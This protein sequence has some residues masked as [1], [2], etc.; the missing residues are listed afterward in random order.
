MTTHT[1]SHGTRRRRS[2]LVAWYWL[3]LLVFL[4]QSAEAVDTPIPTVSPL[5]ST[6]PNGNKPNTI[7]NIL[8]HST[9]AGVIK[10]SATRLM[11]TPEKAKVI[12]E[13]LAAVVHYEELFFFIVLGWVALPALRMQY[14][15]LGMAGRGR[16]AKRFEDTGLHLVFDN[17]GQLSKLALL[18]YIVDMLKVVVQ[19]LGFR[20]ATAGNVP[21]A[22][23]KICYTGWLANRA[24]ALK[25]YL[26]ARHTH[27]D[28]RDLDGQVQIVDRLVDAAIYG[29]GLYIIVDTLQTDI[30]AA[31]KSFLA[32]GSVSTLV[33][34]LAMQ[35]FVAE[36]FNGLFLAGSNRINEG[37]T[38]ELLGMSGK[39][40]NLGWL[41]STLR[42]SDVSIGST[43]VHWPGIGFPF[44]ILD[45]HFFFVQNI[46]VTI[47]NKDLGKRERFCCR[48]FECHN[49][50]SI[51]HK[52]AFFLPARD[53]C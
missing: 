40:E 39:I 27:Q 1:Q 4:T 24:A 11:I 7:Q 45:R 50:R 26:L 13:G 12:S 9:L 19:G 30:G 22:F 28:H 52:S 42:K 46:L 16:K 18:I 49:E 5:P 53:T 23:A 36:L 8:Q 21:H 3:V 31:T 44:L 6:I 37:D 10:R 32:F 29:I 43:Y 25:R 51:T 14:D 35:G 17:L 38:V 34:S 20:W 15:A 33:I 48:C 47:P 41:E 2:S